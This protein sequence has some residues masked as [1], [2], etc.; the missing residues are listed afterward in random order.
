MNPNEVPLFYPEYGVGEKFENSFRQISY[1]LN[2]VLECLK[3]LHRKQ[4][5]IESRIDVMCKAIEQEEEALR[6]APLTRAAVAAL[7]IDSILKD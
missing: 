5:I 3:E 4:I 6:G 1:S 2:K 7:S